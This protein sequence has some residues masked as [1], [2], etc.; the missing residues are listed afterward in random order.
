MSAIGQD[1]QLRA[2]LGLA[3][4]ELNTNPPIYRKSK[5]FK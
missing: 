4:K 5:E 3:Q 2:D 1:A